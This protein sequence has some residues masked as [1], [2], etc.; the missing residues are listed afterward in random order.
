MTRVLVVEAAGLLWGSERSLLSAIAALPSGSVAVCCPR[1][2]PIVSELE[3]IGVR[4][5]TSLPPLLHQGPRWRRL[6]AA[7]G[8]LRACMA[9]RPDLLYLNQAGLFRTAELAARFCNIPIIAH[10]RLFEEIDYL[11]RQGEQVRIEGLIASSRAVETEV[12]LRPSLRRATL[13]QMYDPFILTG[14]SGL[15]DRPRRIVCAARV[16]SAKGQDLLIDALAELEPELGPIECI[17]AGD[18]DPKY[19]RQ[20]QAKAACLRNIQ[21]KWPG[22]VA[23]IPALLRTCQILAFPSER[24]TLG[25]VVL[26]AWDAG[27]VPVVFAGS[28]GAHEIVSKAEAGVIYERQTPRSLAAALRIALLMEE[29]QRAAIALSGRAWVADNCQPQAF[30]IALERLF[31]QAISDFRMTSNRI[32]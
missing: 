9:F 29:K 13:H 30:G 4:A 22:Y 28:G 5:I 3:S 17:F 16:E 6:I 10:F 18:G 19:M 1:A 25:R 20:L 8:I 11:A 27:A 24:E 31:A 14:K 21:V 2:V 7:A 12:L 26:E 23:D 15:V 32:L